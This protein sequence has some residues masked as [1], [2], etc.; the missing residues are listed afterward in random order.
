M[1]ARIESIST[2]I[3]A[4]Q[5]NPQLLVRVRCEDGSV[6]IG[7][8]WWGTYQPKTTPGS[9]VAPIAAMIDQIMGPLCPGRDSTDIAGIWNHLYRSTYQ[10]GPEGITSSALAGID[11]ALWDLQAKRLGVPV[12]DLLGT[13]IHDQLPAYASFHWLGDAE[14]VASAAKRAVQAGF[15]GIKLHEADASIV[16]AARDAI[17]PR[18]A[19]M[20]DISARLDDDGARALSRATRSADLTWLEEPIF[21]HQDHQRLAQLRSQ[22]PQRLAAGENE[23]GLAGFRRLLEAGAIDVLQPDLVKCGGLSVAADLSGLASEHDVWLC[24]HNFSL[25]PSLGA[26]IH[27][28]M[29]ARSATWI[30]VPFLPE[31][32]SFAGSWLTPT[33]VDG[34]IPYPTRPGL[35]WD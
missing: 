12:A 1:A 22:I 34:R 29:T 31:G 17:G 33:L 15:L 26:N 9:P 27:W 24:P 21:P 32:Q 20:V 23:F 30:E 5:N 19:L 8:T 13:R 4:D 35:D 11:L 2:E 18:I 16:L 10:Y 28:A 3:L 6:G 7:E 25:G 14:L